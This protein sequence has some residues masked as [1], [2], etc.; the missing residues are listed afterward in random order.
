MD[1]DIDLSEQHRAVEFLGEGAFA[2]ELGQ[3]PHK[4][5]SARG[6]LDDLNIQIGQSLKE[7]RFNASGLS[8]GHP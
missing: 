5:I 7:S 1:G 8:E 3:L 4:T 6:D 2:T